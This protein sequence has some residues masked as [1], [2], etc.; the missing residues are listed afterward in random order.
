MGLNLHSGHPGAQCLN[1]REQS[2]PVAA[3]KETERGQK[4]KETSDFEPSHAVLEQPICLQK[5]DFAATCEGLTHT[6]VAAL[7]VKSLSGALKGRQGLEEEQRGGH[8]QEEWCGGSQQSCLSA[9]ETY[10]LSAELG[11]KCEAIGKKLMYLED[12]LHTAIHSHDEDLIHILFILQIK[13]LLV[14]Q[15][16]AP[17]G[18]GNSA[19]HD[20]AAPASKGSRRK[21]GRL[22]CDSWP[23]GNTG[24]LG[25]TA[26]GKEGI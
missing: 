25:G 6:R 20:P 21:G 13:Y 16:G 23:L 9:T 19:G 3:T 24:S 14:S 22:P 26:Q 2:Q 15:E 18:E 4:K 12:Q 5:L 1:R 7:Q 17:D 10:I 11:E 8:G